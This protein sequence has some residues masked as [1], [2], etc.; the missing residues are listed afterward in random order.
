MSKIQSI[1]DVDNSKNSAKASDKK[2]FFI[3]EYSFQNPIN[4]MAVHIKRNIR[5]ENT[6]SFNVGNH[7]EI[8]QSPVG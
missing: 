3:K 6:D 4:T 1:K 2:T 7:P 8:R 5:N